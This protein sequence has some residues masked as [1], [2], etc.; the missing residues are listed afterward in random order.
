MTIPARI[1]IVNSVNV[2]AGGL[3]ELNACG[4]PKLCQK[5]GQRNLI[6]VNDDRQY[7]CNNH[8]KKNQY[9]SFLHIGIHVLS[10]IKRTDKMID[11]AGLNAVLVP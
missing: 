6:A 10:L 9:T 8:C 2:Y 1:I 11:S 4:P 7:N 5:H 3:S